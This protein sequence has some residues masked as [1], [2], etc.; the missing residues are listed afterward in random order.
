MGKNK[1]EE[2]TVMNLEESDYE[3]CYLYIYIYYKFERAVWMYFAAYNITCYTQN[4]KYCP[5]FAAE[6]KPKVTL[7]MSHKYTGANAH[8]I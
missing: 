4:Q 1:K 2:E 8:V 5:H 6:M 3:S 7:H